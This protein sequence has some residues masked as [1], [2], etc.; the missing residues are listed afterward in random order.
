MRETDM[1]RFVLDRA[2]DE[3][4]ISGEGV[5]AEG[6]IFADGTVAL[7]WLSETASTALYD[8]IADVIVIHGHGGKTQVRL[9]DG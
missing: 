5:V 9:L 4:G 1:Y 8:S 6:V 7:R 3:T 2:V